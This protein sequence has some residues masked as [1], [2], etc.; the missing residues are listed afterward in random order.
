MIDFSR[1][2]TRFDPAKGTIN[3]YPATARHLSD[4]QGC[5]AD[6]AAYREALAAG[7]PEVYW[8]AT[9]AYDQG[10]GDLVYAIGAILPGKIGREY[11]L[12]RGHYHDWRPAA[13][14]YFGLSGEGMMLLENE[15]GDESQELALRPNSA[16]YVPGFTAHRTVNTGDVPLVYIGVYPAQ[17]GHDYGSL[18]SRNFRM[19]VVEVGGKPTIMERSRFIKSLAP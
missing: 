6:E 8:T 12:T 14:I 16:V 2:V 15:D 9:V 3:G 11:L 17:A 13:E 4:L 7:D 1:L 5:F 18:A 10:E 19:V